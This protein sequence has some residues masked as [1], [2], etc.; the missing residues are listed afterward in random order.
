MTGPGATAGRAARRA[1]FL[2][3]GTLLA[4]VALTVGP[5]GAGVAQTPARPRPATRIVASRAAPRAGAAVTLPPTCP[6]ATSPPGAPYGVQFSGVL[7]STVT[8]SKTPLGFPL[9]V[10]NVLAAFCGLLQLGFD[11]ATNSPTEV[12][13]VTPA[14][15][16]FAP[17]AAAV[18]LGRIPTIVLATAPSAT[19]TPSV[20]SATDPR[21]NLSL[22]GSVATQSSL[23]GINCQIGPIALTLTTAAPGGVPLSGPLSAATATLVASGFTVPPVATTGTSGTCPNFLGTQINGLIGLPNPSTSLSAN[24]TLHLCNNPVPVC[25]LP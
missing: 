8:I 3:V 4:L 17:A 6:A 14:N 22:S 10:P 15:L 16:V 21:L 7:T 25:S 19:S 24:V 13:T 1:S 20:V 23:L 18:G 11:P 5:P 9:S 2:V 12:G